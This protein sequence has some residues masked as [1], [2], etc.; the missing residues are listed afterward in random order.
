MHIEIGQHYTHYKRGGKYEIIHIGYLQSETKDD[1]KQ[2]VIYKQMHNHEDYPTGT[3]WVRTIDMFT[4]TV[5]EN[6]VTVSRFQLL[7]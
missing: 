6:S 5:I 3:V 4:D 2:V 1:G 7:Q